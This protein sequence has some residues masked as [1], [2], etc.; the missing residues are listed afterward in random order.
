MPC[1]APTAEPT[2]AAQVSLPQVL[3][4]AGGMA[5][6]RSRSC[7]EFTYRRRHCLRKLQFPVDN[8]A[9]RL[10]FEGRAA[11]FERLIKARACSHR[12]CLEE[13]G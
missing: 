7:H 3:F 10:D 11:V 13:R 4:A 6:L 12:V 2:T 1:K 8:F 5:S 9:H